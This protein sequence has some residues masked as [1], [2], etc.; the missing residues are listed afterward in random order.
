MTRESS[1]APADEWEAVFRE[2]PGKRLWQTWVDGLGL[3]RG[4]PD[5]VLFR[6]LGLS[7]FFL[8][9]S[10]PPALVD[11]A[12][13]HPEWRV[14]GGLADCCRTLTGEQW[15]RLI[16]GEPRQAR[17]QLLVG[18]AAFSEARLPD[19]IYDRLAG[20]PAPLV[21]AET[22]ELPGVPGRV[23]VALAADSE[24]RVR[25]R[26]C[27]PAWPHL[28]A[29]ARD[30]LLA[31]LDEGVRAA[32]LLR[33]Y[34]DLPMP[35]SYYD[36]TRVPDHVMERCRLAPDLARHLAAA[37]DPAR[38]RALAR[39]PYLEPELVA[40]LAGDPDGEVRLAVSLRPELT[41]EQRAAVRV[42]IDPGMSR[43]VLPW[44]VALYNDPDAMRRLAASSHLLVRSSVARAPRLPPD[45]VERLARDED[46]VVRLFL[47]ES[48]DDAPA[49]MLLE[50]WTW[51]TGSLSHPGRPHS[52]PNFPR[53]GLLPYATHPSGRMRR[54]AL[55]DPDSTAELAERFSRDP[56]EEVRA[57]AAADPRLSAESAERLLADPEWSVR[58]R[59]AVHPRLPVSALVALLRDEAT[60]DDAA[61]N[62][63]LPVAVMH[64]M[65]DARTAIP[66]G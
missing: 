56:H 6:L 17:R 19:A 48:C 52:H 44:I 42:E 7:T 18:C 54:L 28:D 64:R 12:I 50:V 36:T 15:T 51:W 4:A 46:R 13:D 34:E 2:I 24:P 65:I 14:R 9:G 26:A 39:N 11:A 31:D 63:A 40:A 38:R 58:S 27:P 55:D 22:A 8:H 35:R 32:A 47:A 3:N 41:D 49:D 45:V 33:S 37:P 60:A 16:F 59:A 25:L 29:R 5:A 57:R 20:D 61:R 53:T 43:R 66:G 21:R 23:L 1:A 62:P 10:L 30:A